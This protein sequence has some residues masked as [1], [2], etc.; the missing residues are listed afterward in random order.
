MQMKSFITKALLTV[1]LLSGCGGVEAEQDISVEAAACG[2]VCDRFYNRCLF[3]ENRPADECVADW[4]A[5][6]AQFC[7]TAAVAVAE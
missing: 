5:C 3:L 2:G 4:D 6:M 1:G 7:P